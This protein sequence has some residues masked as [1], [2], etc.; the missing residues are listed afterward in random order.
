MIEQFFEPM[1]RNQT[2]REIFKP[3]L[4]KVVTAILLAVFA[5]FFTVVIDFRQTGADLE[6]VQTFWLTNLINALPYLETEN[7]LLKFLTFFT[8]S[9]LIVWVFSRMF[10]ALDNVQL[11]FVKRL[12]RKG[13]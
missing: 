5:H 10:T 8:V 4:A 2:L 1:D 6:V 3:T 11:W 12:R 7:T 9:Y 13:S